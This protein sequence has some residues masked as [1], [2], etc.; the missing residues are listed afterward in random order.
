MLDL[1]K[2]ETNN[3]ESTFLEPACGDGNFLVKILE[4]K[5]KVVKSKYCKSHS[6]YEKYSIVA[7]TTLYG[8]DLLQDNVDACINRL[9]DMWNKEYI[10]ICK[11]D[12]NDTCRSA[13]R[14][15]LN[16][17]ILCGDALTMLKS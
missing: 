14:Y 9:Y 13:C 2:D 1:V 16:R 5:L 12:A 7:I 17:N 11:K 3:I 8:V 6:L 10:S 15:I 4:R